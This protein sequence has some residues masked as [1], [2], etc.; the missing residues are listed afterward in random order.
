MAEP[1]NRRFEMI[2]ATAKMAA[3]IALISYGAS[4]WLSDPTLTDPLLSRLAIAS[5]RGSDEPTT[6]GSIRKAAEVVRLDP[7]AMPQRA[8]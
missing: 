2:S 7:C 6:T 4:I 8:R 5:L 1:D 3:A